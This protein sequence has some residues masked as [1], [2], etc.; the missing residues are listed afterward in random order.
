MSKAWLTICAAAGFGVLTAGVAWAWSLLQPEWTAEEQAA[1]WALNRSPVAHIT[2]HDVF[3]GDGLQ[4]VFAGTDV[5][6]RPWVVVVRPGDAL[7]A[8]V[9]APR[10]LTRA[11]AIQ[12]AQKTGITVQSAHL[13]YLF[14]ELRRTFHTRA[15]LV[16]EVL[17]WYKGRLTDSYFDAESG[18]WIWQY[19][20]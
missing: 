1:Q 7:P 15:A 18:R 16:W 19:V 9:P 13:G 4:E 10:L 6:G 14:P 3:T 2:F 8:A 17:G 5:F 12:V 20:S 11:Q